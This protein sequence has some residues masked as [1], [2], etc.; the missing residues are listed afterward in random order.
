M[1]FASYRGL[2][3]EYPGEYRGDDNAQCDDYDPRNR[4]WYTS[5]S[6]GAKNII[7]LLD[8][9]SSMMNKSQDAI[10]IAISLIY[11][12]GISDNVG[13]IAF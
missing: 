5:A 13:V 4:P 1:Y 3:R 6:S 10:T 11:S 2:F 7:I 9:S 12:L 8:I